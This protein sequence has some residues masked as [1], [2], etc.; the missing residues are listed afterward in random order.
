MGHLQFGVGSTL[1]QS[2]D[3]G[4]ESEN[5]EFSRVARVRSF[6]FQFQLIEEFPEI[7][8]LDVE[9][10][11]LPSVH[12]EDYLRLMSY[13]HCKQQGITVFEVWQL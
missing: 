6:P 8:N 13:P 12:G 2:P 3:P 11:Q 9:V 10:F 5:S 4:M 7:S 1:S